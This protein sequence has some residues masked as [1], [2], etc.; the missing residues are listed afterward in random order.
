MG[1]KVDELIQTNT[2]NYYKTTE[3]VTSK[4]Y[5]YRHYMKISRNAKCPCGSGKKYKKCCI[6][7]SSLELKKLFETGDLPFTETPPRL[8]LP[9]LSEEFLNSKL[10]GEPDFF[11]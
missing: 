1:N 5:L 6:S 8:E 11:F 2:D 4:I 9:T 7:S 10:I 3:E